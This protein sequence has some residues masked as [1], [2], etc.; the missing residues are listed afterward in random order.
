MD[1]GGKDNIR[2]DCK[3]QHEGWRVAST[4]IRR[5]WWGWQ[6]HQQANRGDGEHQGDGEHRHQGT[7]KYATTAS[8]DVNER[9]YPTHQLGSSLATSCAS[10]AFR[11]SPERSR[12]FS[13]S[14]AQRSN[15]R[16]ASSIV[17]AQLKCWL[18]GARVRPERRIRASGEESKRQGVSGG[19]VER[20]M[21]ARHGTI[22]WRARPA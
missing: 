18:C 4:N 13:F 2:S 22:S 8:Y 19:C 3:H 20:R 1:G 21:Q 15:R 10:L 14:R 16:L 5:G 12:L 6:K 7:A 9:G 17:P 11:F